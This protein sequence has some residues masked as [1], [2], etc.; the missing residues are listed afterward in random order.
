MHR[1]LKTARLPSS[2]LPSLDGRRL[3]TAEGMMQG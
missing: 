1:S 3:L 2:E